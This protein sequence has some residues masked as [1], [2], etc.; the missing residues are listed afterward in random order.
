M[1]RSF[2]LRKLVSMQP[3]TG[4]A[5]N[6][7]N[8][9]SLLSYVLAS[10]SPPYNS[11]PYYTAD[12]IGWTADWVKIII[13]WGSYQPNDMRG[14]TIQ[15]FFADLD[16]NFD[17]RYLDNQI[18][19][20]N[21]RGL[22]VILCIDCD[23]APAWSHDPDAARMFAEMSPTLSDPSTKQRRLPPNGTGVGSTFAAFLS[24][25]VSRY[26]KA[27]PAGRTSSPHPGLRWG[28]DWGATI[29]LIEP[30]NEPNY[31]WWPQRI[32]YSNGTLKTTSAALAANAVRAAMDVCLTWY[33]RCGVLGPA[34]LDTRGTDNTQLSKT[35]FAE[36][37]SEWM[38]LMYNFNPQLY[39]AFS[40]HNYGDMKNA[41]HANMQ[42]TLSI[43]DSWG[44]REALV[45]S[46]EGGYARRAPFDD[47]PEDREQLR[48]V[49]EGLQHA[50]FMSRQYTQAQHCVWADPVSWD[51]GL[52]VPRTNDLVN[53]PYGYST[54]LAS[55]SSYGAAPG[56]GGFPKAGAPW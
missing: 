26:L 36:F 4:P 19:A 51:S 37:T 53:Y 49:A 46:T 13:S 20:A 22:G 38:S 29:D 15:E 25:C 3:R 31:L 56:W 8:L 12:Y 48:I 18:S 45:W 21:Q 23:G 1:S 39:Y 55:A 52:L 41:S 2:P 43:L 34:V 6:G 32:R 33:G 54:R 50:H 9:G 44:W 17:W 30:V 24:Y 27:V 11:Q 7:A 40:V 14:R 5:G 10:S 16:A 28:N 47:L 35:D 42:Q